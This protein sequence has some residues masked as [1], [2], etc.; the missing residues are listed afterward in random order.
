MSSSSQLIQ[1]LQNPALFPH[2][3]ASFQVIETHISWI[4]LT[5]SYAYKI[6]KSLNLGFLDFS[7][8]E[9]R[10]HYCHEELRLNSRLA[11]DIYLDV[12]AISGTEDQPTLDNSGK[13]IEYA[14]KMRQFDPD[15]TFDQL[16][17]QHH[18]TTEQIKQTASII[19]NFHSTINGIETNTEFGSADT[20]KQTVLENFRQIQQLNGIEKPDVLK[21][22]AVWSEQQHTALMSVF[23]QRK[24]AGYIRECH[25]DC[26]LGN[27]ALIDGEVVL[28]DGIEF[29]PSLYWIDVICEIAFLV[30]DLQEK[31]RPDLAFQFLNNYLQHSGDYSGLKLLRFYL[32]YRAMV[33]AKVSAIRASQSTSAEEHQQA[34]TSYQDYLQLACSYTQTTKPLMIIMHGVSG[35]GKS[36]LSEQIIDHFQAIRLRSD[37]ERKR[38]HNLSAQQKSHSSLGSG[39]YDQTS[40]DM[41]YQQLLQLAIKVINAD[42]SVIVD[43]TFLQHQQRKLFSRQA[44]Q[45]NIAFLIIHT[46]TDKQTLLKRIKARTKQSDNVS[47]ADQTVLENQLH[48]LQPLSDKELSYSLIIHTDQTTQSI[49]IMEFS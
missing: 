9:K 6:K 33:R 24:I 1:S 14:V 29:N 17:T 16:L 39:L 40:S 43:A 5:G 11:P 4:L 35:S 27:I 13:A 48:T 26:H 45:L 38:L 37:V 18:L 47:E 10:K 41:T 8:L 30:M 19:A 3:I 12:V 21:H 44:E 46:Q 23:K 28:F 15:K 32:V 2:K 31:Q 34:I 7:S 22:L 49:Q 42:Y 25:G 20:I 36:W